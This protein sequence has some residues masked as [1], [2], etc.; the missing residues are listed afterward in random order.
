VSCLTAVANVVDTVFQTDAQTFGTPDR[1]RLRASGVTLT[2]S[3]GVGYAVTDRIALAAD[4]FYAPLTVRRPGD[5][6]SSI[7][8]MFNARALVSYRVIR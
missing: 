8:P 7:D 2:S 4:L 3:A 1:T 5:S 6:A